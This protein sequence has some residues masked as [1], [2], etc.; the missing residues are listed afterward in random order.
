MAYFDLEAISEFK[1][2]AEYWFDEFNYLDYAMIIFLL[3]VL[4][5]GYLY[6][7]SELRVYELELELDKAPT[8]GKMKDL[9]SKKKNDAEKSVEN[10]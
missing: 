9:I 8:F 2:A 3:I 6:Y 4:I 10:S 5:Q 7:K 1:V